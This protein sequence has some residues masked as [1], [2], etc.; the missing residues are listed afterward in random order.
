MAY[1]D[2][3][4]V[5][6]ILGLG[7]PQGILSP[8]EEMAALGLT[9]GANL[10]APATG[11]LAPQQ[12]APAAGPA[13]PP[14]LA[15][16]QADPRLQGLAA[17][18]GAFN[19]L[20]GGGANAFADSIAYQQQ[21]HALNNERLR[22]LHSASTAAPAGVREY[23]YYKALSPEEQEAYRHMKRGDQR[24]SLER[25]TELWTNLGYS[26][27][28][29]LEI[30]AGKT[31]LVSQDGV[32]R[33]ISSA[34]G[35]VISEAVSPEE[36]AAIKE[37]NQRA[38]AMG[39]A[40]VKKFEDARTALE[41]M[42]EQLDAIEYSLEQ[43]DWWLGLA[44]S[45]QLDDTGFVTGLV[46]DLLGIS[47][48]QLAEMTADAV[49]Q[50]LL[51]LQITNLAPVTEKELKLLANM[52]GSASF[53]KDKIIGS[54]RSSRKRLQRSQQ[55]INQDISRK[56]KTIKQYGDEDDYTFYEG[57]FGISNDP[58]AVLNRRGQ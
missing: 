19:A 47:S 43:T 41:A 6:G 21:A 32:T 18:T 3:Y 29:A 26:D 28:D 42:P 40:G 50:Q 53:S 10:A 39:T 27:A 44:E 30:Q 33:L 56:L 38:D 11:P 24:T 20:G 52:W 37:A 4:Q 15:Q 23:E 17:I 46:S 2:P 12:P 31:E 5:R 7:Q 1:F 54:L 51:N 58:A 25:N 45:G 36:V 34:D 48:S 14:G 35:R 16:F 8:E 49:Q 22:A 55:F 57:V 13:V 9:P